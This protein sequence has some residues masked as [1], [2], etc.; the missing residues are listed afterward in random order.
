MGQHISSMLCFAFCFTIC[1]WRRYAEYLVTL[2]LTRWQYK[3]IL[4]SSNSFQGFQDTEYSEMVY[5]SP[6]SG[7]TTELCAL[8]RDN[9]VGCF[10]GRHS[11]ESN[12]WPLNFIARYLT[13]SAII[14]PSEVGSET[15]P[16]ESLVQSLTFNKIY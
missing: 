12:V 1:R 8:P 5:H 9:Q 4:T 11:R 2:C 10:P 3:L 13:H 7:S 16:S 6:S 14:K 15:S